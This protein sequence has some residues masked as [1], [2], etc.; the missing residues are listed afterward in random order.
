MRRGSGKLNL[1]L[2]ILLSRALPGS[3]VGRVA[4]GV[5]A[6][7][8]SRVGSGWSTVGTACVRGM[9]RL[10][11]AGLRHCRYRHPASDGGGAD[12]RPTLSAVRPC[13]HRWRR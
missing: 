4:G 2:S 1:L 12:L 11:L 8:G 3:R 7:S 5:D 6:C 13:R 10:G 9:D